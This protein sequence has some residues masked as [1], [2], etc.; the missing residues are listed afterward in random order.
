MGA[1][2]RLWRRRQTPH[3]ATV[4]NA[5]SASSPRARLL[6]KESRQEAFGFGVLGG[7]GWASAASGQLRAAGNRIPR[8]HVK[9]PTLVLLSLLPVTQVLLDA[10]SCV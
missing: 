10:T 5:T 4:T 1:A 6:F 9:L 8:D 3:R 2:A 7:N